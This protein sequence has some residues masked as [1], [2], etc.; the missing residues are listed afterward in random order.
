MMMTESYFSGQGTELIAN[1]FAYSF[2]HIKL[3]FQPH[4]D[5]RDEHIQASW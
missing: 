3:F 2:S 1:F 4:W 5:G